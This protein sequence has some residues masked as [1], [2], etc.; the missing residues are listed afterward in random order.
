MHVLRS[1]II[2]LAEREIAHTQSIGYDEHDEWRNEICTASKLIHGH[3][4]QTAII[5]SERKSCAARRSASVLRKRFNLGILVSLTGRCRRRHRFNGLCGSHA[6]FLRVALPNRRNCNASLFIFHRHS[7]LHALYCV[8]QFN[9]FHFFAPIF[10][11]VCD[12]LEMIACSCNWQFGWV[13]SA[14]AERLRPHLP[15]PEFHQHSEW[16]QRHRMSN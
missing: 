2:I 16:N 11:S 7:R 5:F 15:L 10:R 9:Y 4:K 6:Q 12:E 1:N 3:H 13:N 8:G 14:A